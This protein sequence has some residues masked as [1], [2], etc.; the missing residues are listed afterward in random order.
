V[1]DQSPIANASSG[2]ESWHYSIGHWIEDDP[3][4][5]DGA[6]SSPG[7]LGWY[8]WIDKSQKYYGLMA[9]ENLNTAAGNFEGYQSA[10]CGR[11][12]RNAWET[13]VEQTGA[14]PTFN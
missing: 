5:G 2:A 6:F 14:A 9:R 11:L 1:P 7:A 8:P 3:V 13:G 10:V 4:V 12:M